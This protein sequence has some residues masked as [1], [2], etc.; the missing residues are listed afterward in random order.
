[1]IETSSAFR[2]V[3]VSQIEIMLCGHYNRKYGAALARA[4]YLHAV[5]LFQKRIIIYYCYGYARN[6]KRNHWYTLYSFT[7]QVE[8]RSIFEYLHAL[9]VIRRVSDRQVFSSLWQDLN[10]RLSFRDP[11]KIYCPLMFR[12]LL[13]H[14]MHYKIKI[15]DFVI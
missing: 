7:N 10:W 4:R 12:I 8:S 5:R 11:T 13:Q 6:N 3:R 15:F 1:M 9:L 14:Y 2:H